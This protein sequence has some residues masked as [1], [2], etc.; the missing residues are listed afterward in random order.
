MTSALKTDFINYIQKIH[1]GDKEKKERQLEEEQFQI[2]FVSSYSEEDFLQLIFALKN[3]YLGRIN[4]NGENI[5]QI[6]GSEKFEYAPGYISKELEELT[7]SEKEK[8]G[9]YG[10]L[11]F[12]YTDGTI[13][14]CLTVKMLTFLLK[15][16]MNEHQEYEF[17][18]SYTSKKEAGNLVIRI[19]PSSTALTFDTP[20]EGVFDSFEE[21]FICRY[22][23]SDADFQSLTQV[24][25]I[26]LGE[27]L[28]FDFEYNAFDDNYLVTNGC[29]SYEEIKRSDLV[30]SVTLMHSFRNLLAKRFSVTESLEDVIKFMRGP[31]FTKM[32][33]IFFK[34]H[35]ESIKKKIDTLIFNE[36]MALK[37]VKKADKAAALEEVFRERN[38]FAIF[39]PNVDLRN[40]V[41]EVHDK[42]NILFILKKI[43]SIIV[44]NYQGR[45]STEEIN[46]CIL[47]AIANE[48]K[49]YK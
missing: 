35:Q 3:Q 41:Q 28:G 33:E 36:I 34:F 26:K 22:Y 30:R 1:E 48:K 46:Q 15:K 24:Q 44:E 43:E 5:I 23:F 45:Y 19:K 40:F 9:E 27:Y 49:K 8:L 37:G 25:F 4:L 12:N 17:Y 42:K 14:Y 38:L 10:I 18:M 31:N 13:K 32:I 16:M 20:I 47:Q 2:R 6:K 21:W 7:S 39:L 29:Y 11:S